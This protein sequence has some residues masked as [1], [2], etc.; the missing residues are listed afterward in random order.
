MNKLDFLPA[1]F[2]E[3]QCDHNLIEKTLEKAKNLELRSNQYNKRS[4]TDLFYDEELYQWLDQCIDSAK[5]DIGI[6]DKVKLVITSCWVNKTT[7]M[8]SHHHHNHANSFMS[9]I[10]YLTDEHTGGGTHFSNKSVWVKDF[11]WLR[12]EDNPPFINKQTFVPK[13]GTLLLFP[14]SVHHSVSVVKDTAVRYTLAFNTFFSGNIDETD[15]TLT[16]LSILTKS[17]RD[18][19]NET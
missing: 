18:Y 19:Y 9:G 16:R 17:V 2:Y 4:D 11:E 10:L 6:N 7:K 8:Q 3:F 5:Q 13:K 15:A 12:F 14:S 1:T